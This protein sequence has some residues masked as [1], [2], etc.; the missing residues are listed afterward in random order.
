MSVNVRYK[1]LFI[2]SRLYIRLYYDFVFSWTKFSFSS[3]YVIRIRL[4]DSA[5]YADNLI[6]FSLNTSTADMS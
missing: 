2:T 4:S 6:L 5:I 3:N 1:P